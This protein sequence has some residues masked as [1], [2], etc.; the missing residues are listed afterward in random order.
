MLS[1]CTP[2]PFVLS[3]VEA[4]DMNGAACSTSFDFAQDERGF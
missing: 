1:L 3:E 4:R 2:S